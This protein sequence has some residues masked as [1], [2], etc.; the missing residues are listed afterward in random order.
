MDLTEEKKE[1]LRIAVREISITSSSL[2]QDVHTHKKFVEK[3]LP[4]RKQ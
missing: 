4:K 2:L 1:A 3:L